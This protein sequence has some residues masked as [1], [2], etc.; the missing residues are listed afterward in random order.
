MTADD[1][2]A[3]H[4]LLEQYH[5]KQQLVPKFSKDEF[6]HW[7]LPRKGV[8]SSFVALNDPT[9][10]SKITDLCSFYH[11][12]STV[13]GHPKHQTLFAAYSFYNVAT[14]VDLKDLT[15][16]LM[17]MAKRE[18]QDVFN[19]LNLMDNQGILND[20]K[21]GIGDGRLQYYLY[22]WSCPTMEAKDIGLVLL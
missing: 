10:P 13:I 19:A 7:L 9:D 1:V 5:V 3:A 11:L 4:A 8:V 18:N 16:D 2:P 15:R 14:T 21:F 6:A 20:L 17:I 12:P 22:N